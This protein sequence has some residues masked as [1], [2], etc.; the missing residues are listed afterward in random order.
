MNCNRENCHI[1]EETYI[2]VLYENDLN[3][4]CCRIFLDTL[5]PFREREGKITNKCGNFMVS[6]VSII[7]HKAE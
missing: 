2:S 6:F 3:L 1:C 4:G 7:K 5:Y